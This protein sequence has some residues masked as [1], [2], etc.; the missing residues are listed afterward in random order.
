[1]KHF[2]AFVIISLGVLLLGATSSEA[3]CNRKYGSTCISANDR[4]GWNANCTGPC[5]TGKPAVKKP[6]KK[7]PTEK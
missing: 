6:K 3:L 7:A 5:D 2:V 1:M 4:K